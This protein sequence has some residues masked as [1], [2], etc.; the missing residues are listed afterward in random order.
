MFSARWAKMVAL[1][2]SR[3]VTESEVC[4]LDGSEHLKL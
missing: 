1:W 2:M 4:D 3:E